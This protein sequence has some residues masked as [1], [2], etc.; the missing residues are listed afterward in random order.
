MENNESKNNGDT[1]SL[2][3]PADSRPIGEK[4]LLIPAGSTPALKRQEGR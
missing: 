3:C 1:T 4:I 2:Q